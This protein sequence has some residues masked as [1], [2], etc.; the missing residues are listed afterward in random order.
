MQQ[1]YIVFLNER[2]IIFCEN[3]NTNIVDTNII[4]LLFDKQ[5]FP[6][7]FERFYSDASI[8]EIQF[9]C[10]DTEE[11]FRTFVQMFKFIKA[12]GG[13]V[14]NSDGQILLIRRYNKWDLPKGKLE[15]DELPEQGAL[16]EVIEETSVTGLTVIRQLISTFHIFTTRKGRIALKETLW[17][18]M[19]ADSESTLI[20]QL[21]EDITEVL[22][23]EPSKLPEIMADS[24]ASLR[25]L[26]K[27]TGLL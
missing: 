16:R 6:A 17:F 23:V 20:P 18:E 19:K 27:N 7:E 8:T 13:I 4:S 24:Y 26:M 12:A 2:P 11:A 9:I 5:T 3:I 14:Y 15:K 25:Y 1:K 21:E 10:T 22:W